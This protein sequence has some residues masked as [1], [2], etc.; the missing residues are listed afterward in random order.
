MTMA[1]INIFPPQGFWNIKFLLF[2][3]IDFFYS[4]FTDCLSEGCESLYCYC[5]HTVH[6]TWDNVYII[7]IDSSS[8]VTMSVQ[9]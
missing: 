7:F 8:K 1:M 5:H 4:Y 6:G 3:L 2:F 9:Q